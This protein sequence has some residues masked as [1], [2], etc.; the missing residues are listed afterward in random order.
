MK[1]FFSYGKAPLMVLLCTLF[2]IFAAN[3]NVSGYSGDITVSDGKGSFYTVCTD[4]KSF[5]LYKTDR[6]GNKVKQAQEKNNADGAFY[7]GDSLYIYGNNTYGTA[8]VF[9]YSIYGTGTALLENTVIQKELITADKSGKLYVYDNDRI[10]V[11]NYEGN[12]QRSI[13]LK[14][15]FAL[16]TIQSDGAVLAFTKNGVYSVMK[17][18]FVFSESLSYPVMVCGDY[19][20]DSR[21]G[22]YK[23][24]SGRIECTAQT[25]YCNT[26]VCGSNIY[27]IDNGK[28]LMLDMQSNLLGTYSANT[29]NKVLMASGSCLALVS[30]SN[31]EILKSEAF[32]K[33]IPESSVSEPVVSYD[34]HFTEISTP[35]TESSR[36]E[37]GNSGISLSRV[38]KRGDMIIIPKGTTVAGVKTLLN[39]RN[40][41]TEFYDHNGNYK[42]SGVLGT[43]A[44]VMIDGNSEYTLVVIGDVTGEGN[45][46]YA[47]TNLFCK[48]YLG[49]E[50]FS[51]AQLLA[52][53][54]DENGSI[55]L[56]DIY[57]TLLTAR[58]NKKAPQS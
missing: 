4:G 16:K 19:V 25:G 28:V 31:I 8:V 45:T 12:E 49:E 3:K 6:T 57:T 36:T 29:E 38:Q 32:T 41:R 9:E 50:E 22:V 18:S 40:N 42:K 33:Y 7:A 17:N 14:D 11:F 1:S 55:Q 48:Y 24:T 56:C 15:V 34:D 47:D 5:T 13:S 20:T 54:T 52:A 21:G 39:I 30:G 37:N 53:D 46:N 35:K 26:V 51:D 44:S 27:T 43:G 23:Y 2:I 58:G 10:R